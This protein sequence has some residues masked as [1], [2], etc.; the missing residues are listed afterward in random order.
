MKP[1]LHF[2]FPCFFLLTCYLSKAQQ[3]PNYE[4]RGAWIATVENIDWPSK[5]SLS[6]EEQKAE[7][8]RIAEMHRRNGMNALIV[9]IRPSADAFYPSTLEPWSEYLS[10]KQGLP[11]SPYYDPLQFMIEE[12]HKRGMEFH[13]WLN[14]YRAVFNILRSSV[15]PNHISKQNPEWFVTYGDKKYFNPGIPEVRAHVAAVVED[16]VK[17]YRIDAIHMD[18]YFYPYKIPGREFPD[19]STFLKYGKGMAK[20]EWRRSN[21]DSIIVLLQKTIRKT[22]PK[23]KFGISPFGVWRNKHQDPMG[24]ETRSGP[25]NYDELHAD[26]LLWLQKGWIDYIV[27]QLYWERGHVLASYDILLRWWNE[28]SYER[29]LYIGHG[30]YRAGS[31][32]AWKNRNEIPEQIKALRTHENVQGSIYYNSSAFNKNPNGWNDSLQQNYYRYPALVPPMPWIDNTIP[33]QP[34]VEKANEHTYKLAYKGEEKIKGFAV[35]IHQGKEEADFA[36]SQLILFIPGDKT[37]VIDLNTLPET[38][39]KKVLIASVDTD[40]NVSPLRLLQ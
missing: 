28:H 8:I 27:P 5:R 36:N 1:L 16:I 37:A 24:S 13:A 11:P 10:G 2:L 17:R 18:D 34:L 6:V 14:P 15:A 30:I 4:F 3:S 23:V 7:F 26:V 19:Q 12:T 9:Q 29:H 39:N 25:T 40:N 35:F 38:K 20:D 22:N 32:T 21:C 31:N 33:P